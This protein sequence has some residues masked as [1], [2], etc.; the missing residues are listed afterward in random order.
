MARIVSR[1]LL[2][3]GLAVALGCGGGEDT[4]THPSNQGGSA[5]G[6]NPEHGKA[7]D[8]VAEQPIAEPQRTEPSRESLAAEKPLPMIAALPDPSG[9]ADSPKGLKNGAFAPELF[10]LDMMSGKRFRLSDW[11]GPLAT[12]HKGAVVVGFTASWCGPC[13]NSYPYLQEMKEKFGDELQ[14]V[15]LTTD[16]T[17]EAKEKHVSLIRKSGLEAPLLDP[18][19]DTL[20][21]WLGKRRNVPHFYVINQAGEI[22]VQDRGFGK[23]VRK[24]LPGQINYAIRNPDYV[25]RR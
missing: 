7:K 13:K 2:V 6:A 25:V 15:L 1:H 9:I 14:V 16:A 8:L 21:A 5:D 17:L 3:L 18:S 11:T 24:V 4:K 22:L 20:R 10:H 19:P 23:K 12:K